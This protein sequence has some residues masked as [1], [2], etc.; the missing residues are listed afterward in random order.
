MFIYE[1][2]RKRRKMS[3]FSPAPQAANVRRTLFI[4]FSEEYDAGSEPLSMFVSSSRFTREERLDQ[5][6]GKEL[7]R[8][9]SYL[10][11]EVG[12]GGG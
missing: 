7:E 11:R 5:E 9:L 3:P 12:R 10:D 2:T 8:K 4:F 6:E 1:R